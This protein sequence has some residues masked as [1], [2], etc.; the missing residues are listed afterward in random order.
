VVLDLVVCTPTTGLCL[1]S[2]TPIQRQLASGAAFTPL[3]GYSSCLHAHLGFRPAYYPQHRPP[4]HCDSPEPA[5][6]RIML[7]H[8][9][10]ICLS[11]P[12]LRL[13]TSSHYP[14]RKKFG[15]R[16][17]RRRQQF[18][19]RFLT[20]SSTY[21]SAEFWHILSTPGLSLVNDSRP[22]CTAAASE[23]SSSPSL[24]LNGQNDFRITHLH[25]KRDLTSRN[26]LCWVVDSA[27]MKTFLQFYK[28]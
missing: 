6:F 17:P 21:L 4:S 25:Q 26:T 1:C 13:R 11:T 22:L 23:V 12:P 28:S 16:R 9:S 24:L 27:R 14:K 19:A 10:S 20:D 15:T 3:P 5:P 8:V 2:G 18:T 7:A